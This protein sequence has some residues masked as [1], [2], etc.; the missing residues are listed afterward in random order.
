MIFVLQLQHTWGIHCHQV[1]FNDLTLRRLEDSVIINNI[2]SQ[3]NCLKESDLM[4]K[5]I[6]DFPLEFFFLIQTLV[7]EVRI[8]HYGVC[9]HNRLSRNY[10]TCNALA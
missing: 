1:M 3:N 8:C 5:L 10:N 9:L 4:I 6:L 7:G 2:S